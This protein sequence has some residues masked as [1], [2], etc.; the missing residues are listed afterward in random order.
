MVPNQ[1]EWMTGRRISRIVV[2]NREYGRT[3]AI[4][5]HGYGSHGG[6]RIASSRSA[7]RGMK[8]SLVSVVSRTLPHSPYGTSVFSSSKLTT[9][10]IARGHGGW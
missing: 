2:A 3:F 4:P 9:S 8:N 7:K 5:S 10:H 6:V 1:S